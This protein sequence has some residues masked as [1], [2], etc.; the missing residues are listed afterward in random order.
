MNKNIQVTEASGR[1]YI[2]GI[3]I[4]LTISGFA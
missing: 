2:V 4:Q 1:V 3:L